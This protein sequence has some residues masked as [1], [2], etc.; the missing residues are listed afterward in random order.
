MGLKLDNINDEDIVVK[1]E[2][3]GTWAPLLEEPSSWAQPRFAPDGHSILLRKTASPDCFLWRFDLDRLIMTRV[4]FERDSHDPTWSPDGRSIAFCATGEQARTVYTMPVDGSGPA[5]PL[6]DRS[7]PQSSSSWS[8]TGEFIVYTEATP[9]TGTDL[10]VIPLQDPAAEPQIFLQ[11]NFSED[12][13]QFSPNG[14]WIAYTSDESGRQEVYLR[15]FPG[16]GGKTQI[17]REGGTGALWAPD[18]RELFYAN[19]EVMMVV[20]VV[21][22]EPLQVSAPRALFEGD[23]AFERVGNYDIAP[24]GQSFVIVR[25]SGT[26]EG[27]REFRVITNALAEVT[28]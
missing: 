24:D 13:A 11:T 16:P 28:P 12:N 21:L 23:F 7:H 3:D 9:N 17:S 1:V 19:G 27:R 14:N 6:M 20:D 4:T 8:P 22:E 5:K 26:N 15:P 25:T 18:G 10:W 2:R